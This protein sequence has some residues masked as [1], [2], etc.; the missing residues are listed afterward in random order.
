LI[1]VLSGSLSGKE[2]ESF[3]TSV[4]GG[5]TGRT[6]TYQREE[7]PR[8]YRNTLAVAREWRALMREGRLTQAELARELRV[9]RAR[10]TQVLH[11]LDIDPKVAATIIALGDPFNRRC[12]PVSLRIQ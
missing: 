8:K 11:L 5:F 9:S 10:L 4:F 6:R 3:F 12:A 2:I 1:L 7:R